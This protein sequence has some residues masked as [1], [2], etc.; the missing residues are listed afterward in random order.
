MKTPAIDEERPKLREQ[1]QAQKLTDA[2]VL[3]ALNDIVPYL[4]SL[5]SWNCRGEGNP[6][7]WC[8]LLT[9][10]QLLYLAYGNYYIYQT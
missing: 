7:F 1:T 10:D 6:A 3:Q 8:P 5:R 4:W 2:K 9:M